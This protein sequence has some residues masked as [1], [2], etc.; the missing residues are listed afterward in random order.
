M[1]IPSLSYAK[2]TVIYSNGP[3]SLRVS[4]ANDRNPQGGLAWGWE[5]TDGRWHEEYRAAFTSANLERYLREVDECAAW[6]QS[7]PSQRDSV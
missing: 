4:P 6:L 1:R 3:V 5:T 7:E 2:A